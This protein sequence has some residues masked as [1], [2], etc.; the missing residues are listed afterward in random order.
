MLRVLACILLACTVSSAQTIKI[1][2]SPDNG[3]KDAAARGMLDWRFA[4]KGDDAHF[5]A[6]GVGIRLEKASALKGDMWKGGY[7]HQSPMASDGVLGAAEGIR[8]TIM[9]LKPGKHSVATF[10]NAISKQL[11]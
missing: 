8:F 3:R 1:D 2:I 11:G 5:D 4:P 10:H 7:G 6:S 9:G